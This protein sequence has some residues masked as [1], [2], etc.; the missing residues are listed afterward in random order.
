MTTDKRKLSFK[1][2]ARAIGGVASLSFRAAPGAV[3]FKLGG[4]IFD[5]VLPFVTTYYAALTT[6]ALAAA[7]SGDKNASHQVITYVLITA[8]LG[9]FM[10]VWRS[11]DQYIQAQ[12]RF[13]VEARV[14]DR[15]YE[16]FLA[17][18]FWHYDDKDTADLYDKAQKF[19]QFFAYVFD[20]I[21]GVLSQFI[22]MVAG[23][24]ALMLVNVW[25]ALFVLFALIP[26]VYLQFK[27]SKAQVDHWN[28]NVD[29]R[30]SKGMIE[31]SL[32]QPKMLVELRLYGMVT[33]LLELRSRLRDADE[34]QRIDFER[35]YMAKRLLADG[36]E[37][38]AEVSSLIWITTQVIARAQPVGQ[39][40][41]VQQVVSRAIGGSNSFVSQLSGI[42]EDIANLFDYEQFM[43]LPE[44]KGG[45]IH[46]GSAPEVIELKKISFHYPSET[47]QQVLKDVSMTIKRNQHV[48][49][50]G[51]NGAGKSTL[52]KIIT[53]VY[54][55]TSGEILLDSERLDSFSIA[56]WH[57]Q[58]AVLQQEFVKYRFATV[59]ENVR[60]GNV[61]RNGDVEASLK[62]AE[63]WEFVEKLPRKLENYV[64]NWMEDKDGNKGT[65][66]SGGQWQR[67]AL[68]RN[69]YRDAPIIIL[70]EP[71]SAI[72]A[73]AETRIFERLLKAKNK[74]I[75]TISHRL[76]TVE[77]ADVIHMLDAGKVVE[78][79]THDEL[80]AMKGKYYTM[81]H[82]Q[83]HKSELA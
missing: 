29:V 4:A 66:L 49:I 48:A 57:K 7:Y 27:L 70:D 82:S 79:G 37:A 6:T 23:V 8:G 13:V 62:Q 42:D 63:A 69:F 80:V 24:G 11:I 64:D 2:Q 75:I 67:L 77:K 5:A 53:G 55:P 22:T 56:S 33:H 74:T 76:T 52:I 28:K 35:K 83:L 15:M 31:W 40:L 43:T 81:F 16:H 73:L 26:G 65:D 72:D 68:A 20:R 32:L 41:Y 30:R 12:M 9:L 45:D 46:L 3:L 54:A 58:L 10:T 61:E 36:L 78:S 1:E 50:V 51:E 21:A 18:D 44:R 14:A 60:F 39:F 17:L 34:K 19:S 71:T 47:P 38:V 59:E 25:L